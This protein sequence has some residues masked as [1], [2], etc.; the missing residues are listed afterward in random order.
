V[1]QKLR[2]HVCTAETFGRG[3]SRTERILQSYRN[4][5]P[6]DVHAALSA[7]VELGVRRQRQVR[8]CKAL[9]QRIV[10]EQRDHS[11]TEYST[12]CVSLRHLLRY[13]EVS[14]KT[15]REKAEKRASADRQHEAVR[16]QRHARE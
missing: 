6:R 11:D 14:S 13:R 8:F 12:K 4:S 5:S 15:S 2:F 7:T 3:V 16:D 9:D 1:P 10:R